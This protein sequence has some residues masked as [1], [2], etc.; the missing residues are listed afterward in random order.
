MANKRLFL[1]LS[2][3]RCGGEGDSSCKLGIGDVKLKNY[4][5]YDCCLG[6]FT[7]QLNKKIDSG[8]LIDVAEPYE[9]KEKIPFLNIPSEEC[10]TKLA[11]RCININDNP[12]STIKEKIELLKKAWKPKG[13]DIFVKNPTKIKL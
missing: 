12:I 4:D 6:L 5:G 3:W 2:K 11:D 13:Y 8:V 9:I 10:N 7:P 1:D